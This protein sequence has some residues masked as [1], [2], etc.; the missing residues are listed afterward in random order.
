MIRGS[1]AASSK[2]TN[3]SSPQT[4]AT[5]WTE[6]VTE[7]RPCRSHCCRGCPG[8]GRRS[9]RQGGIV[10]RLREARERLA[11]RRVGTRPGVPTKAR[12]AGCAAPATS[13]TTTTARGPPPR[14]RR[15][16]VS[17]PP[18]GLSIAVPRPH[19]GVPHPR[20]GAPVRTS[21]S[22][23][24]AASS[25]A[26]TARAAVSSSHAPDRSQVPGSPIHGTRR[27][28]TPRTC[29]APP[30]CCRR[31][32]WRRRA[33][34]GRRRVRC[35]RVGAAAAG[36]RGRGRRRAA[37]GRRRVRVVARH[38]RHDVAVRMAGAIESEA[39]VVTCQPSAAGRT[40]QSTSAAR[41]ARTV[42]ADTAR[43]QP[44]QVP[45]ASGMAGG[46]QRLLL[47]SSRSCGPGASLLWASQTNV[48][49]ASAPCEVFGVAASSSYE[50]R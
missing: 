46:R 1:F 42:R 49:P 36:R 20:Q 37:H 40:D 6:P 39:T 41:V 5:R 27:T 21:R 38:G 4:P 44:E 30:A 50:N 24:T 13:A 34:G 9:P 28:P 14:A 25:A 8:R 16:A 17:P 48:V 23:R 15:G 3:G 33:A 11:A 12:P 45:A 18:S 29:R 22:R 2:R 10:V 7:R 19:R 43:K 47:V 32:G 35:V 26:V 31:P